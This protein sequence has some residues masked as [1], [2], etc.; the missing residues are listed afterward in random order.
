[1]FE[2]AVDVTIHTASREWGARVAVWLF[3]PLSGLTSFFSPLAGPGQSQEEAFSHL[4]SSKIPRPGLP[5]APTGS[6]WL[7][8]E[9]METLL[10][11][12]MSKEL[13]GQ[14]ANSI[15]L[16]GLEDLR[17]GLSWATKRCVAELCKSKSLH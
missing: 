10:E 4:S 14:K 17:S 3:F 12:V 6:L 7:P 16:A 1:M 15:I 2:Q 13:G 5:L 8:L 11:E 9:A